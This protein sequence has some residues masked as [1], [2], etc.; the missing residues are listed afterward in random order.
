M[1]EDIGK[2]FYE[3]RLSGMDNRSI[4]ER[5]SVNP[6][7]V[8]THLAK[9]RKKNKL[10][11]LKPSPRLKKKP[12]IIDEEK[13]RKKLLKKAVRLPNGVLKCPK[14]TCEGFGYNESFLN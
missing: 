9:Y 14:M 7:K 11:A 10:P 12:V 5:F 2:K 3:L 4:A 8:S 1:N 13:I 6:Q